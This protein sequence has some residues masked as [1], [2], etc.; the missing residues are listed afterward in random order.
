MKDNE[1]YKFKEGDIAD[2]ELIETLLRDFNP[3]VIMNLAAETH[4]DR[5]INN[6][7]KFIQT[8]IIGTFNLLECV[9][10]YLKSESIKRDTLKNWK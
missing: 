3:E 7:E 2:K 6:P 8:N 1:K 4:V 5:S 9:R 10:N